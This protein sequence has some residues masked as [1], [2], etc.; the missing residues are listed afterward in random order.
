MYDTFVFSRSNQWLIA[1]N[2][3]KAKAIKYV[4]EKHFH[5]SQ[6]I[7]AGAIRKRLHKMAIPSALGDQPLPDHV[8]EG[9]QV[10]KNEHHKMRMRI[11][12]MEQKTKRLKQGRE[13]ESNEGMNR[14]CFV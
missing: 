14:F 2:I 5:P 8:K 6:F 12:R 7:V 11:Y 4:C 10:L 9:F 3:K 13:R 1:T